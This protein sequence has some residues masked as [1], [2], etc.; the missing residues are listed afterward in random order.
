MIIAL[1]ANATIAVAKLADIDAERVERAS[2][3]IDRRLR[4]VVPD[5]TEVFLD[6]TPPR[7]A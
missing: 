6:A 3:E 5:V 1:A 7:R 2:S 4:E